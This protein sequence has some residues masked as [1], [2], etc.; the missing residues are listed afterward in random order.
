LA[1]DFY[2]IQRHELQFQLIT[3]VPVRSGT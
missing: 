1:A 2:L 3:V